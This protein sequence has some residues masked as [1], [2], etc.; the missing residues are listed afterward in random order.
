MKTAVEE[1]K[2]KPGSAFQLHDPSELLLVASC[3]FSGEKATEEACKIIKVP[4]TMRAE[5]KEMATSRNT[6]TGDVIV[7]PDESVSALLLQSLLS[8]TLRSV[9]SR[10]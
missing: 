2:N 1:D 7:D 4:L 3:S 5:H 8:V 6:A 9:Y 10:Y